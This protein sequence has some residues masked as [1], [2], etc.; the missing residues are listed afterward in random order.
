MNKKTSKKIL[1]NVI[2]LL[3]IP[4]I[5]SII[6]SFKI[7]LGFLVALII[8]KL[9]IIKRRGYFAKDING[10]KLS[11]KQFMS[12]W[13]K[14]IEGITPLQSARTNLLGTWIVISGILSGMIINAL[15]RMKDQWWWIEII[16]LGSLILTIM[17]LIGGLQK[18][19]R[20]KEIDKAMKEIQK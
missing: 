11:F 14:G 15:V 2:L 8:I 19:W 13:K 9:I 4:I 7:G 17:Q 20:Y 1:K 16:L 10:N 6:F 18:Y 3:V 12:R 5:L